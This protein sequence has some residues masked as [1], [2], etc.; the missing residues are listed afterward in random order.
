V[1]NFVCAADW[2]LVLEYLKVF[3]SWPSVVLVLGC[4]ALVL[5]RTQ[6]G[7]FISR[8]QN[9]KFPGGSLDAPIT[10]TAEGPEQLHTGPLG[11]AAGGGDVNAPANEGAP[12]GLNNQGV[13]VA[14]NGAGPG[15]NAGANP[16]LHMPAEVAAMP[17]APL[18]LQYVV[19]RPGPTVA[20]FVRVFEA[21]KF[22]KVLNTIFGTQ[23]ELIEAMAKPPNQP[24]SIDQLEPFYDRH[25]ALSGT[26]AQLSAWVG[27]LQAWGLL[28]PT[29]QPAHYRLTPEGARFVEY[30]HANYVEGAPA[31]GL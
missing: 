26:H 19:A 23:L 2:E 5:F 17:Q 21:L 29:D 13:G 30:R 15:A 9:A 1:S 6:I 20:E 10:Q 12:G 3:W 31:R 18:M 22:E 11:A 16:D 27:Y 8:I 14:G 28:A 25:R 7:A 24:W 4:L